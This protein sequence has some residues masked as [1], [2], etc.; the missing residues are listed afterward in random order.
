MPIQT[1]KAHLTSQLNK[2][3]Q[4]TRPRSQSL[5]ADYIQTIKEN[6]EATTERAALPFSC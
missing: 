6:R 2:N 1:V 5:Q 4:L 3:Q